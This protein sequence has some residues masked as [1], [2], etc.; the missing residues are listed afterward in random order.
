MVRLRE[1]DAAD[2]VGDAVRDGR[3]RRAVDRF[4]ER[5]GGARGQ[6]TAREPRLDDALCADPRGV[7]RQ[8][9]PQQN[10]PRVQD[11]DRLDVVVRDGELAQPRLVGVETGAD[12]VPPP[13]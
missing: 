3:R 9:R 7:A 6:P 13:A 1:A 8:R 2:R 12:G 10:R 5:D 11:R 4:D